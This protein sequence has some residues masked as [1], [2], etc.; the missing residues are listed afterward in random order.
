MVP[1][2][3]G[4]L[5]SAAVAV[6]VTDADWEKETSG[7]VVLV[8]FFTT[9]CVHCKTLQPHW[10]QLTTYW[11]SEGRF[12][13]ETKF[14]EVNCDKGV[15]T[16]RLCSEHGKAGFPT[17]KWGNPSDLDDVAV[18]RKY[19]DLKKFADE[20][21]RPLCSLTNPAACDEEQAAMLT[22]IKGLDIAELKRKI[23]AAE[24]KIQAAL[25]E[26]GEG[27]KKLQANYRRDVEAYGGEEKVPEGK[28]R[29]MRSDFSFH[30]SHIRQK[31]EKAINAVK[32][33][34]LRLARAVLAAKEKEE[35]AKD[36]F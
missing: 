21:L 2:L 15:G 33:A 9:D 36:E 13:D 30:H 20:N 10:E 32:E 7:K 29:A 4:L 35:V 3:L 8:K 23:V 28:L 16:A 22:R 26:F 5:F 18:A 11:H 6:E 19:E 14:I 1:V 12:P 24:Q 17:I 34:G 31:K 27:E 25:D